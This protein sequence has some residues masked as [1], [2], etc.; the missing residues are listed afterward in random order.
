MTLGD[1]AIFM[2]AI[3]S[4][5]LFRSVQVPTGPGGF[6]ADNRQSALRSVDRFALVGQQS[7]PVVGSRQSACATGVYNSCIF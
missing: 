3:S 5:F 1:S 7:R 6:A 2:Q 4:K